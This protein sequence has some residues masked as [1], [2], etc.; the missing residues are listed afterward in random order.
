LINPTYKTLEQLEINKIE[1]I[2]FGQQKAIDQI[3]QWVFRQA[4]QEA[5]KN[6]E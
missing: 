5:L 3:R 4:L 6:F 1:A 2:H